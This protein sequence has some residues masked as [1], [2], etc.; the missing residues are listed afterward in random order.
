MDPKEAAYKAIRKHF[1]PYG[2]HGEEWVRGMAKDM[3]NDIV[4]ALAKPAEAVKTRGELA[5]EAI[6]HYEVESDSLWI[7]GHGT[8][9]GCRPNNIRL[10]RKILGTA[11]D[12]Q[13]ADA[14]KEAVQG[15]RDRIEREFQNWK[16]L[17]PSVLHR[18]HSEVVISMIVKGG[19]THPSPA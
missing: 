8:C 16:R 17:N 14:A 3:A 2:E 1:T 18:V 9:T 10:A 12:A 13:R 4:A 6:L 5:A 7:N 19:T 11:I 15:E